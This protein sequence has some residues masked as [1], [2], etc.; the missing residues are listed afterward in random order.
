MWCGNPGTTIRLLLGICEGSVDGV[1][2][3]SL[4]IGGSG[5]CPRFPAIN[6]L[7]QV[8]CLDDPPP[9]LTTYNS[10]C[11]ASS[12]SSLSRIPG[13]TNGSEYAIN[14]DGWIV[15]RF[16]DATG[17]LYTPTLGVTFLNF[18]PVDVNNEGQVLGY[19]LEG[20]IHIPTVWTQ[21]GGFQDLS[22]LGLN[23]TPT[24]TSI[25]DLGE[26]VGTTSVQPEPSTL[27]SMMIGLG[28]ISRK[29]WWRIPA[30][31]TAVLRSALGIDY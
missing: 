22:E 1:P 23:G 19:R 26:V 10:I 24:L 8:G 2:K 7:G 6:D 13:L 5:R 15:G 17:F 28:L 4:R 25:N 18:S 16:N 29:V 12:P 27:G 14:N 21:T 9:F 20:T 30:K 31:L 3:I 11:S